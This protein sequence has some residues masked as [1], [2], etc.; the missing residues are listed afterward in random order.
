M[1]WE[2]SIK[3]IS[4]LGSGWLGLPLA[5]SFINKGFVVK[6]S[7]RSAEKITQLSALKAEAF[8][9]DVDNIS[10]SIQA[11]LNSSILIIN[12]TSKNIP[13]FKQLLAEIEKSAIEKVLFI[14]STSVYD[15]LNQTIDES[16]GLESEHKPLSQIEALFRA[17]PK[18]ETTI[19][20]FAGL[21]GYNRHPGRFFASG[22]VIKD[23]DGYVNLIH[24]DD[25]IAIITQLI[26]DDIW[27]EAF[28]CCADTHP[29]KRDYY[30]KAAKSIGMTT[31]KF[32]NPGSTAF[33][34]IS[35][36][37]IKHRL[38]YH[39]LHADL[40]DMDYLS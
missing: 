6:A 14:S 39:F 17:S 32:A 16:M 19:L 10:N 22:K 25:C 18:I 35:N 3:T 8:I 20:R 7:T 21:I 24:R 30:P 5:E 31:P 28:N 27:G 36:Q 4:I 9:V 26:E 40:M 12:I 1:V 2:N 33:K 34:I 13:G 38:N 29:K 11:F 23:P 37:K 15:N